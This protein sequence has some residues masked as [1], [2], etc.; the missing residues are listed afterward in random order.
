MT[1]IAQVSKSAK[2]DPDS[3]PGNGDANEDDQDS[4]TVTPKQPAVNADLELDKSVDKPA[5]QKGDVVTFTIRVDNRGPVDATGV[6]AT[7]IVPAGLTFQSITSGSG[8]TYN[9]STKTITWAIGA[10]SNGDYATLSY[11]AKVDAEG[12]FVNIAQI[13]K[14]DQPDGDSTPG[15]N[16]PGEDDQSAA[17]V[18]TSGS[19]GGGNAGVESEGSMASLLAQRLFERRQDARAQTALMAAPEPFLFAASSG[20][21][22]DGGLRSIVPTNGPNE[23]I[24]YEVTPGDLLGVTNATNVFAADYLRTEGRRMGALFG[25]ISPA[26]VLYDH[27]KA[28]CDRLG[29]GRLESIGTIDVAGRPFVMQHLIHADGSVDY[30]VSLVAYRSGTDFVVD[31]RFAYSDYTPSGSSS[32]V[33]LQVWSVS[34]AYTVE[35]VE[36]LLSELSAQGSV[37]YLNSYDNVPATPSTFVQSGRYEEGQLHLRMAGTPSGTLTVTGFA[38]RTETEAANGQQSEFTQTIT[39]PAATDAS[40]TY[41]EVVVPVGTIF[42]ARFSVQHGT[43]TSVDQLYYAD[44]AWSYTS[45]NATVQNFATG[46]DG[47]AAEDDAYHVERSAS[48]SGSVTD[49]ASMFR[50][51]RPNGQPV[52]LTGYEALSFTAK[53][54]GRYSVV[55]E[56]AGI[57]SWDQHQFEIALTGDEREITIPLSDL[58]RSA[59]SEGL[60]P[61]DVTLLAFYALG[62]NQSAQAF[63]LA[64]ENVRFTRNTRFTAIG[65]DANAGELAINGNAPNPF[66]GRTDIR[67]TLP[68]ASDARIEIYDLTGRQVATVLDRVMTAGSHSVPFVAEG[69]TAGVYLYRLITPSGAKTGQMTLVR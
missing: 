65:D 57:Q 49:F 27:A 5:P 52:D 62:N 51:F 12:T 44:G 37:G 29:G 17:T 1:N 56:K 20:K 28:T 66:A 39:L 55:V 47:R 42:D 63:D 43:S 9:A 33:N 41:T 3:T 2:Y 53:G 60:D 8:A 54:T 16:N 61:S 36:G 19:S 35:L 68:T 24:A 34:P 50:Y 7:D 45:G 32:V 40:A 4:A 31:S 58:R 18:T 59:G 21:G 6:E 14:S 11:T 38:A 26:G 22:D 25:A 46:V 69:L 48:F 64:V 67:F 10:L 30:A 23:S 15:N 13:S